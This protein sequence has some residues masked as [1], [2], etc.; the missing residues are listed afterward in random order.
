V[1]HELTPAEYAELPDGHVIGCQLCQV[2][3]PNDSPAFIA[4][5]ERHACLVVFCPATETITA[6]LLAQPCKPTES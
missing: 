1:T 6:D 4:R 5:H 3:D 2:Y